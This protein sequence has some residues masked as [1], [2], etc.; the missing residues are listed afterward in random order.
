MNASTALLELANIEELCVCVCVNLSGNSQLSNHF[1]EKNAG[2]LDAHDAYDAP[3]S[4]SPAAASRVPF[5]RSPP[6]WS[7]DCFRHSTR[8]SPRGHALPLDLLRLMTR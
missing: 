7:W 1:E 4:L 3:D 5:R 6:H 2:R 8:R